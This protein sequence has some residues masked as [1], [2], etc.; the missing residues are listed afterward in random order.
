MVASTLGQLHWG[1]GLLLLGLL[2]LTMQC[3]P[4]LQ[5]R[6][7]THTDWQLLPEREVQTSCRESEHYIPDTNHLGFWPVRHIRL[8]FHVMDKRSLPSNLDSVRGGAQALS[9][10]HTANHRL[11]NPVRPW[12][13]QDNPP[14]AID[15]R[16]RFVAVSMPGK[17]AEE[18]VEFHYDEEVPWH[19]HKGRNQNIGNDE[20]FRRY[21]R[22]SDSVINVFL[23]S[24]HPDSLAS[25]RY[26][27][28]GAGVAIGDRY[29]KLV[30]RWTAFDKP[31]PQHANLI[32]EVGHM[33]TL[34]HTWA[35]NDGCDD[36]PTHRNCWNFNEP[37]GCNQVSNN[38]MDYTAHSSALTPCQIGRVYA[39]ITRL[40][41]KTRNFVESHWCKGSAGGDVMLSDSLVLNHEVDLEGNLT[42]L[43]GAYLEVN[44]R[45]SMPAQHRITVHP[46]ATLRL[47]GQLHNSCG[48][49]WEGIYLLSNRKQRGKLQYR[50]G[51]SI[52]N[53]THAALPALPTPAD[54]D[55]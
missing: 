1:K 33:Y 14:P 42:L 41:S 20:A 54:S 5:T 12:L 4:R 26:K 50:P 2:A 7:T 51:A 55:S 10:M 9:I 6:L 34:R 22:S 53:A 13:P 35:Q 47:N 24:H 29:L 8:N 28:G 39:A 18:S 37:A 30:D 23:L 46:G 48:L 16:F 36:T 31:Y 45:L 17:S 44:C 32:H 3:N 49:T 19:V 43:P 11:S 38:I 27:G 21:G 25:T 52:E 15:P 40:D